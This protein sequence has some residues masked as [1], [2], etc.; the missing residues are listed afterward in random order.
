VKN[1]I[2]IADPQG[3]IKT[4]KKLI[5]KLPKKSEIII[6]GDLID[7][8]PNSCEVIEYCIQNNIKSVR[9]N[10]DHF[11]TIYMEK[12]LNGID[13]FHSQ[14]YNDFGGKQ[15]FDSYKGKE[16]LIPKHLEYMNS[17]PLYI[18]KDINGKNYFIT[19]GFAL[20]YY[21]LK[22]DWKK[23]HRPIMSNRLY[24]KFYN[25]DNVNE[26]EKYN[27]INIFGHDTYKFVRRH[28]LYIAIDTGCVYGKTNGSKGTL[29]A[30]NLCNKQ[31]IE[32]TL[33][34]EANYKD[35]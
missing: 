14:W 19:H 5:T 21:E 35:K 17:L 29:T 27:T 10:H 2:V 32:Q 15:T 6:A 11:F 4:L 20:P 7:K 3:C 24:G 34:D 30:V 33:I 16:D 26:L 18:E 8:G 13:I 31:I 9:G 25:L 28:K 12:Y 1:T 23:G 22:N